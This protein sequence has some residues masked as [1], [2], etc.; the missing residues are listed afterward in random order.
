MFKIFRFTLTSLSLALFA[1]TSQP[2]PTNTPDTTT[3]PNTNSEPIPAPTA[4][5]ISI[6]DTPLP[7]PTDPAPLPA[8]LII[9]GVTQTSGVGT[10]C[11]KTQKPSGESVNACADT[12]GVPTAIDPLKATIPVQG[13]L[14]LPITDPPQQLVLTAY[15]ALPALELSD[16]TDGY[17]WW[18]FNEGFITPLSLQSSQAI[19]I[20]LNRGLYVFY[21]FAAWDGKGDVSYGFLVDVN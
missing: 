4:T 7:N 15:Q 10:Y 18:N 1:C 9:N 13:Q 19:N 6:T 5:S 20:K 16:K 8:T 14:T 11:W 3:I 21:V 12:T 2:P 17:R